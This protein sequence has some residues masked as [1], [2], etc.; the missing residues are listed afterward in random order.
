MSKRSGFTLIELL[1]VIAI[2]AILAAILFPVFAKA[3][4]KAR[5]AT[6]LSNEKQIGLACMQ[7]V[8]DYDEIYPVANWHTAY[9]LSHPYGVWH[10]LEPY[11][12][13]VGMLKCP[14]RTGLVG[15]QQNGQNAQSVW[16]VHFGGAW[17]LNYLVNAPAALSEINSPASVVMAMEMAGNSNFGDNNYGWYSG[18]NT[19]TAFH[20]NGGWQHVFADGHAKW[21]RLMDA[22]PASGWNP[23][24]PQYGISFN[25]AYNP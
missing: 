1:V 6:C 22:L 21:F 13:S 20:H 4:E 18:W 25:K 15:Y 12:K 10:P 9:D 2:I 7:Y 24:I 11:M 14:S 23:T 19:E 8:Q 3:R 5:Q 17:G 16:G